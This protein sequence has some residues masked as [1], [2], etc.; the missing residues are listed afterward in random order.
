MNEKSENKV[1]KT[2]A[3]V[4]ELTD[5]ELESVSA[6]GVLGEAAGQVAGGLLTSGS[7]SGQK[8]G[9][10]IGGKVEDKVDQAVNGIVSVIKGL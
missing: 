5:E 2:D 8:I 6:A 1:T 10:A 7:Q 9:A 3:I 4:Q